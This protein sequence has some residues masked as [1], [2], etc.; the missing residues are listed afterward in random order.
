MVVILLLLLLDEIRDRGRLTSS[1]FCFCMGAGFVDGT[2][3]AAKHGGSRHRHGR[4]S[5]RALLCTMKYLNIRGTWDEMKCDAVSDDVVRV[6][7]RH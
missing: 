1:C 6:E 7:G 5:G 2:D 4:T 3:I